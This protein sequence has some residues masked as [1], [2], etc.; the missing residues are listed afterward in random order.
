VAGERNRSAES[1]GG[2]DECSARRGRRNA[3]GKRIVEAGNWRGEREPIKMLKSDE[4]SRNVYENKQKYDTLPDE[5]ENISIQSPGVLRKSS[6]I[7]QESSA[8]IVII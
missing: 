5:D 7:L 4:Q 3:Q 2:H 1:P 8:F 6:H